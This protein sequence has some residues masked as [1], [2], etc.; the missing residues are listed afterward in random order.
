MLSHNFW[1]IFNLLLLLAC[2]RKKY[3][4][5]LFTIYIC[6]NGFSFFDRDFFYVEGFFRFRDIAFLGLMIITIFSLKPEQVKILNSS[7]IK[8]SIILIVVFNF[9]LAVYTYYR[10]DYTVNELIAVS[11]EYP[12]YLIAFSTII[13]IKDGKILARILKIS[14]YFIVTFA[15]LFIIQVIIGSRF[16]IFPFPYRFIEERV[17]ELYTEKVFR[18]R[19]WGKFIPSYF[20]PLFF[21]LYVYTKEKKHL[22]FLGLCF[23]ATVLT[24]DRT[25][26][27]ASVVAL[28]LSVYIVSVTKKRTFAAKM[29]LRKL[30]FPILSLC[31]L[32]FFLNMFSETLANNVFTRYGSI[33]SEIIDRAGTYGDRID[34]LEF[35]LND[36]LPNNLFLGVGLYHINHYSDFLR[37]NV[38]PD[39]H[40]GIF[41][42][43]ITTGLI[44]WIIYFSFIFYVVFR[45]IKHFATVQNPLYKSILFMT[46]TS[47]LTKLVAWHY[48]EFNDPIGI[49]VFAFMIGLSELA[50]FYDKNSNEDKNENESNS[51]SLPRHSWRWR[52]RCLQPGT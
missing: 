29:K 23:I 28:P 13:L 12:L 32:L 11:R 39:G 26:V 30:A 33:T 24:F 43:L 7:F 5:L 3:F 49:T 52:T 40:I 34:K 44:F 20:I 51:Y 19:A 1:L 50:I 18:L 8:R 17:L 45:Y 2:L 36:I 4:F 25:I 41:Y 35:A 31:I 22:I 37:E 21:S 14:Q 47:T 16:E 46:F 6:C 38:Y 48:M 15:V 42:I 27:F 10:W 9:I